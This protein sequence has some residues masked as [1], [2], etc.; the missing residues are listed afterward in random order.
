MSPDATPKCLPPLAI[1]DE[2]IEG[3]S[4]ATRVVTPAAGRLPHRNEPTLRA[5]TGTGAAYQLLG[6]L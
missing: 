5:I 1:V 4:A 6:D 2:V 3:P